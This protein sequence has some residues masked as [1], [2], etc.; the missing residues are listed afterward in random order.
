MATIVLKSLGCENARNLK[1]GMQAWTKN[2]TVNPMRYDP[3]A[4]G[5]DYEFVAATPASPTPVP[6]LTPPG[7]VILI[8]IMMVTVFR[9]LR[10]RN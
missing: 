5:R 4:D 7:I 2:G 3:E 6:T 8:E 10:R 1:F 9:V